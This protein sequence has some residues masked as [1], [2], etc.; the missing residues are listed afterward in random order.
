MF[1][2][3]EAVRLPCDNFTKSGIYSRTNTYT[4]STNTSGNC[5]ATITPMYISSSA[6]NPGFLTV[7]NAD[8][9]N[10]NLGY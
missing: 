7:A 6:A 3:F 8:N 4:L 2:E 9:L 5:I 1:P 10:I